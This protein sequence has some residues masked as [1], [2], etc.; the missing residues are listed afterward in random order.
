MIKHF[1]SFFVFPLWF[2]W[3]HAAGAKERRRKAKHRCAHCTVVIAGILL[4][5]AFIEGFAFICCISAA[6]LSTSVGE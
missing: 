4:L 1:S 3:F 2:K 6:V 5:K